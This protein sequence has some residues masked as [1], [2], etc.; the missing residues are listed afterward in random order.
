MLNINTKLK[1]RQEEGNIIKTGIIGTGQMGKGLITQTLIMKGITPTIAAAT[2]IENVLK[3]YDYAGISRD[4][5]A[6][7]KTVTQANDFIKKGKYVATDDF[8]IV[9]K[10]DAIDCVVD[11][12]GVSD[13]GALAAT[14]TI[15]NGKHMVM[16]NVETDIIIGPL[17]KKMADEK[18]VIY[19]G[20]AGDEPGAVMELYSFADAIGLDIKVIGKGKNNKVIKDSNP[21]TVLEEALSRKMNPRMLCSFKDETKTMVELCAMSNATGFKPDIVGAHGIEASL[22]ELNQKFLLKSDGGILN[23]HPVV[24]YV[25]GIAPGVFAIVHSDNPEVIYQMKYLSMG[26]GP[27]WTLYR[28][29]HLCILETPLTIAKAV[30]D[31]EPT[32]VPKGSLVSECFAVAKKDLKKGEHLDGIGG[33]TTY[34][35]ITTKEDAKAKAY[36]PIGLI[37]HNTIMKEDVKKGTYL[38]LNHL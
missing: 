28:P 13:V 16:L 26:N 36:V 8:E 7:A 14:D 18:G 1:K 10:A 35:S 24:E 31:K 25:M 38:T 19:T 32:I 33:Y 27:L 2:K 22:K 3:A 4:D 9:T 17:L 5:I 12:T 23:S 30:I 29:Y 37:N 15:A 21:D 34:G 11:A 6:I 20:S